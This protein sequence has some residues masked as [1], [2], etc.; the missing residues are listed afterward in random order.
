M[1]GKNFRLALCLASALVCVPALAHA[2]S[3]IAGQ[4]SGTDPLAD[5]FRDPPQSARPR[6][7]W[8]W[9]NGNITEDGI[10]KDMAWMKRVGIG[11]LQNFDVNLQTPQ[12]VDKRLVY[13]TPEWKHA[14]RFAATEAE[15]QGLELT[16]AASPGWSETGGP[17][18]PAADGLKKLV[19]SETVVTGGKRFS[20]KLATP[21][22][23]TG[24]FQDLAKP[25]SIEEMMTGNAAGKVAG[26]QP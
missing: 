19:W 6:V 26:Q 8:H 7:W 23:I 25:P 22:A 18:V 2:E 20:G 5:A 16:I 21:P 15:R 17:W 9:M 1:R 12:I 13:M 10:A 11:G 3:V 14:F 4:A 24:P